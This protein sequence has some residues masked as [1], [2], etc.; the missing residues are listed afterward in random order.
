MTRETRQ[1]LLAFLAVA[2]LA[3]ALVT[4]LHRIVLAAIY[5]YALELYK[6]L[7]WN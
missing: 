5:P 7:F 6:F 3:V 2:V 1:G 4:D